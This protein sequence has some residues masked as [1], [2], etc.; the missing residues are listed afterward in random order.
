MVGVLGCSVTALS[1]RFGFETRFHAYILGLGYGGVS[2]S[3]H[4]IYE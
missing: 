2:R 4:G 1:F 3:H